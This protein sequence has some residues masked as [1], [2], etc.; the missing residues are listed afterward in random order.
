MTVRVNRV[1]FAMFAIGPLTLQQQTCSLAID[2]L[3]P[4][5]IQAPKLEL[6]IMRYELSDFERS[7]IKPMLPNKPRGIPRVDDRRVEGHSQA[8]SSRSGFSAATTPMG[9]RPRPNSRSGTKAP[10]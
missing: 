3:V 8:I 2:L 9:Q 7:V 1:D 6:P 10:R 4:S 5:V